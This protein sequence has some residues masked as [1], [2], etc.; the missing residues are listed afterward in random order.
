MANSLSLDWHSN[1]SHL[2]LLAQFSSVSRD[3]DWSFSDGLISEK[4]SSVRQPTGSW[5][6]DAVTRLVLVVFFFR[7]VFA[8]GSTDWLV[9]VSFSLSFSSAEECP[10]FSATYNNT[11]KCAWNNTTKNYINDFQF[12]CFPSEETLFIIRAITW[13]HVQSMLMKSIKSFSSS[14]QLTVEVG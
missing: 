8:T 11:K 1:S 3:L 7:G 6:H 13:V 12:R 10:S 2:N 14:N 9:S 5:M 4:E